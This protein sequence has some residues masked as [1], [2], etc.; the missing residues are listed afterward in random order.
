M[1][2]LIFEI[3]KGER[4]KISKIY[5]IGDKK[6]KIKRLRDV[7][8]SED[9]NF[10]TFIS[11]NVSLNEERIE[12]DKRLLKTFYFSQGFY[13]FTDQ[14]ISWLE[15]QKIKNGILNIIRDR[16]HQLQM[17]QKNILKN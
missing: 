7:I 4:Q 11:R 17:R 13:D 10:W 2:Y 3:N 14:T 9:E 5:F 8:A 12:Y 16:V 1:K 6:I 15:K